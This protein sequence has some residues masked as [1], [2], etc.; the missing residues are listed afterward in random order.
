MKNRKLFNKTVFNNSK[1]RTTFAHRVMTCVIALSLGVSAGILS[2]SQVLH[3]PDEYVTNYI[4]TYNPF[5]KADDRITLV[6]IDSDTTDEYGDYSDWDRSLLSDAVDI[7]SDNNA[8]TIALDVDLSGNKTTNGDTALVASGKSA[9]NVIAIA[10]ASF[11]THNDPDKQ[12]TPEEK[13]DSTEPSDSES[14][15]EDTGSNNT[16]NSSTRKNKDNNGN[17]DNNMNLA[18]PA[19]SSM[20]WSKHSATD[21][22]YPYEELRDVVTVGVSNAMQ[23]SHDGSIHSAALTVNYNGRQLDSFASLVYSTY[24]KSQGLSAQYPSLDNDNLFGFNTVTN[25][26]SYNIISF[27]DLLSGNYSARDFDNKIVLIGELSDEG[28][29]EP[30]FKFINSDY[31]RQDVTMQASII[32]TLLTNTIKTDVSPIFS[33]ILYAV[34]ISVLYIIMARRKAI[35]TIIFYVASCICTVAAT[36]TIY[37][38]AGYRFLLLIPLL[39]SI[40]SIICSL[41]QNLLYATYEKRKMENTFK[42]YVDSHVVDQITDVAPFELASVSTRKKIAVLFVDIRGFTSISESLEPEEVVEVLNEYFSIVYAS[43]MAWNG[44]L[45]KFIGDA[46]MAIF[47]APGDLDDYMFNAVCAADDIMK[48]FV[49]IRDNFKKKFN[50]DINLGIGINCG[51]AIVGNIGCYGRYDYTAIGDTI[52]TASRLESNAKPGQILIS[53]TVFDSLK[54]RID[55]S[56]IGALSLKGKSSAVE[57]YM[58]ESITKPDAPNDLARKGFLHE[59]HLLYTKAKPAR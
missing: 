52:N 45:D 20:D 18:K 9:G 23:Q 41:M 44:T 27:K 4:Y 2:Y 56:H 14:I 25:F 40:L 1:N 53:S 29:N 22:T 26:S 57:T 3:T 28:K 30:Y 32:Q 11:D 5:S 12:S 58:I 33:A 38:Q 7:L 39:Y 8:A 17:N 49:P 36:D 10:D 19:D 13:P 31:M 54:D 59:L 42:M 43:I 15:I 35:F 16:D 46:A 34:L 55:V 24:Q 6:S 48:G 50:R 51:D 37:L 47:N 21:I